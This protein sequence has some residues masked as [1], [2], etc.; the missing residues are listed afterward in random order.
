MNH[1]QL[2][3]EYLA[4]PKKLRAAVAGMTAEQLNAHP[5]PGKWSIKEVVCHIADYEPV[6]AT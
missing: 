2:I 3:D 6:Y 4:G 1:A 5:I